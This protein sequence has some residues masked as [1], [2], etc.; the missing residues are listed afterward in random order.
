MQK[1][2]LPVDYTEL[3][4][5]QRREVRLQYIKEQ[6]GMCYYCGEDLHKEPPKEIKNKSID[7]KLFPQGFLN[8]PIHLQHCHQ[9]GLTEGAVHSRCNA[10]M[11][12][13]EG[14]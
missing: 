1:Y 6:E 3:T 10:F 4:Q 14:R 13:Y 8:H 2:N 9:T 11:W 7:W 12:Q 5:P